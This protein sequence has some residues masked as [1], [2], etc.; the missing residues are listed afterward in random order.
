MA[1]HYI[2]D[3]YLEQGIM[4]ELDGKPK[5]EL[6]KLALSKFEE[7]SQQMEALQKKMRNLMATHK[8]GKINKTFDQATRKILKEQRPVE[9]VSL[10]RVRH[11]NIAQP[12]NVLQQKQPKDLTEIMQMQLAD[13]ATMKK[14]L[15][16][17]IEALRA[18]IPLAERHEFAAMMLSGRHGFADKIQQSVDMMGV[19]GQSYVRSCS[20]TIDA[21]MQVFPNGLQWLKQADNRQ[22]YLNKNAKSVASNIDTNTKKGQTLPIG[23]L[24]GGG[25]ALLSLSSMSLFSSR[26]LHNKHREENTTKTK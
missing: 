9:R 6:F 15:D 1:T 20:S 16:S 5:P 17:T 19:Y 18:D 13:L 2:A 14:Q 21:T 4:A 23:L 12:I 26:R 7:C 3:D 10:T 25:F 8:S 22:D 11:S 24:L